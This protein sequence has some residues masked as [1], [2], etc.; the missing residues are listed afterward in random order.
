MENVQNG[1]LIEI[2]GQAKKLQNNLKKN[3]GLIT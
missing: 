1:Y 3:R 2:E